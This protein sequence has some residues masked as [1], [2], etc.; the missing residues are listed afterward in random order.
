MNID[1]I[2]K[3]FAQKVFLIQFS[4]RRFSGDPETSFRG[5]EN[6]PLLPINTGLVGEIVEFRFFNVMEFSEQQGL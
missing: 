6:D 5:P 2:E 1:C 4:L 3:C